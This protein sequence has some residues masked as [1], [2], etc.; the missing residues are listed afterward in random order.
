MNVSSL[1]DRAFGHP[2]GILGALGGWIMARTKGELN[3]VVLAELALRSDDR[4]LEVGFGPGTLLEG[5]VRRLPQGFVAGV[6]PSPVMVRQAARRNRRAID[7]GRLVL[8][9]A[10]VSELPFVA[11]SFARV[12]A[13]HSYQLWPDRPRDLQEVKRVLQPDGMLLLAFQAAGSGKPG[14]EWDEDALESYCRELERAGFQAA[15]VTVREGVGL[16]RGAPPPA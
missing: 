10:G 15:S 3:E 2:R 16:V 6:D 1:F 12:V 7:A 4:V 8:R 13:V 14:P 9:K 5:L 11:G